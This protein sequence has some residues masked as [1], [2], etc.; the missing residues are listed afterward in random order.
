MKQHYWLWW[1]IC[2][3]TMDNRVW[4]NPHAICT[5]IV[6]CVTWGSERLMKDPFRR[7]LRVLFVAYFLHLFSTLQRHFWWPLYALVLHLV[8]CETLKVAGRIAHCLTILCFATLCLYTVNRSFCGT[9]KQTNG[10]F[11]PKTGF[12][13]QPQNSWKVSLTGCQMQPGGPKIQRP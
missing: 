12:V 1:E 3:E 10:H 6:Y 9:L 11:D 5:L 13:V 2:L 7:P 8:W 4:A